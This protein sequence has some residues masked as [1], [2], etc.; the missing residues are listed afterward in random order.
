[1]FFFTTILQKKSLC[2]KLIKKIF[3]QVCQ[4]KYAGLLQRICGFV[5]KKRGLSQESKKVKSTK[6]GFY[7]SHSPKRDDKNQ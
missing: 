1:M 5:K 2:N 6:S 7:H 4:K 3:L